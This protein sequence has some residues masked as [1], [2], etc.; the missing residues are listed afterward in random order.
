[1]E[2][3]YALPQGTLTADVATTLQTLRAA[4]AVTE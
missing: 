2:R 4:R 3:R 1:M